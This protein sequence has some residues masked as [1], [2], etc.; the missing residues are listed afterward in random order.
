MDEY[1]YKEKVLW[2]KKIFRQYASDLS[3]LQYY[4]HLNYYPKAKYGLVKET[5][6]S[7]TGGYIHEHLDR[8]TML[9]KRTQ[10]ILKAEEVIGKENYQIVMQDFFKHEK[11][12]WM[13]YYSRATYYRKK[14]E[15]IDAFLNYMIEAVVF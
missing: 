2:I 3:L 5:P 10:M 14:R 1:S 9:Q 8:I 15:A 6:M 13:D 7:D 11:N 4:H 12:W